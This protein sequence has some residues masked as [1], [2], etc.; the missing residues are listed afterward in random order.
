[1]TDLNQQAADNAA[2]IM[3]APTYAGDESGPLDRLKLVGLDYS[4]LSQPDY[5]KL[6][7][8]GCMEENSAY[9][10][11]IQ[12]TDIFE[13]KNVKT[14][15]RR[16]RE[17]SVLTGVKNDAKGFDVS[18]QHILNMSGDLLEMHAK[19]A[20]IG[21]VFTKARY[22]FTVQASDAALQNAARQLAIFT[23]MSLDQ[24]LV[25]FVEPELVRDSLGGSHGIG[26]SYSMMDKMIGYLMEALEE[27]EIPPECVIL[28]TNMIEPGANDEGDPDHIAERTVTLFKKYKRNFAGFKLLSG[29][30][31]TE[32]ALRRV[33]AIVSHSKAEAP[34]MVGKISTSFSRAGM[35]GVLE[36]YATK[37][38]KAAI[39]KFVENS[40]AIERALAA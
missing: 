36:A 19:A 23:R 26:E 5:R 25:Q 18:N 32:L 29:G 20:E 35:G 21:A 15:V 4:D 3:A 2:K 17:A 9:N 30:Q 22:P 40:L 13:W 8:R 7:M 12:T 14:W 31:S 34:D 27:W 28:K 37:G 11:L 10:S 33:E 39:A 1:M 16:L 38:K 24:G 6:F